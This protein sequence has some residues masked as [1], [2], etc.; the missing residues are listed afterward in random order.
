MCW[1]RYFCTQT[2]L[3][4]LWGVFGQL[5]EKIVDKA[6]ALL[7]IVPNLRSNSSDTS[8]QAAEEVLNEAASLIELYNLAGRGLD[9]HELA[10]LAACWA[11]D[12]APFLL[13]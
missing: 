7:W 12:W 5:P 13:G 11:L 2:I 4:L 9:V 10:C 3:F 8:A 1:Q 6:V